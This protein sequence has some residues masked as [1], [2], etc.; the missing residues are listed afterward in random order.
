MVEANGDTKQLDQIHTCNLR[1]R[2][3]HGGVS[4][5]WPP[6]FEAASIKLVDWKGTGAPFDVKP[7]TLRMRQTTIGSCILWAWN[8]ED[9]KVDVPAWVYLPSSGVF[10]IDATAGK[11]V[12]EVQLRLML[13]TL[14]IDR[15]RLAAHR[16]KR[17]LAV[18]SLSVAKSGFK[19]H[20]STAAV[21]TSRTN[22]MASFTYEGFAM[23]ELSAILSES[24][25]PPPLFGLTKPM[26]DGTGLTGRY[27]ITLANLFRED[28]MTRW[29]GFLNDLH[30]AGLEVTKTTSSFDILVVDHVE[31]RPTEN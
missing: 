6:A 16:E 20:P 11:P 26:V 8:T 27:D 19:L 28:E 1:S 14:L 21:K 24:I 2:P 4:E 7:S 5:G 29:S 30:R 31:K 17:D 18:Y 9:Y 13:Q 10:D 22:G 15:F 25:V 3:F 12:A 23:S